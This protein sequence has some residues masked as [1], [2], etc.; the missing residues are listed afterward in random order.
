MLRMKVSCK[1]RGFFLE[2]YIVDSL[3]V[4][5]ANQVSCRVCMFSFVPL[6]FSFRNSCMHCV[7][8]LLFHCIM[9]CSLTV[10][11]VTALSAVVLV[12][13]MT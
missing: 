12:C 5:H 6:F 7:I 10:S 13:F 8:F 3:V 9:L 11:A 4:M 2:E 1:G